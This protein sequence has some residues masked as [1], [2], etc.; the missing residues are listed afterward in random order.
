MIIPGTISWSYKNKSEKSN[1]EYSICS[2]VS[3]SLE[4]I[5]LSTLIN[6]DENDFMILVCVILNNK[7]TNKH[8]IQCKAI[9]RRSLHSGDIPKGCYYCYYKCP[10]EFE[11]DGDNLKIHDVIKPEQSVELNNMLLFKKDCCSKVE[12]NNNLFVFN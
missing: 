7:E 6:K 1:A 3:I 4:D 11:I 10:K 5:H 12:S 9:T 8:E 2:K